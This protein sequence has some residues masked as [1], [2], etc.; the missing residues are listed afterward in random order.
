MLGKFSPS[1]LVPTLQRAQRVMRWSRAFEHSK[2]IQTNSKIALVTREGWEYKYEDKNWTTRT[3]SQGGFRPIIDRHDPHGHHTTSFSDSYIVRP[4]QI[5]QTV[6]SVLA[7]PPLPPKRRFALL[8]GIPPSNQSRSSAHV[9]AS[10]SSKRPPPTPYYMSPNHSHSRR[11]GGNRAQ[12]VT[13]HN[14]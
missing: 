7:P 14:G 11:T 8:W 2:K 1:P 4:Q 5:H 12:I 13:R 6:L 9:R 10:I 3:I